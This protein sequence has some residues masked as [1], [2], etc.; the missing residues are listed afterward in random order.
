M[1]A[2]ALGNHEFDLGTS[3]LRNII[4]GLN[5]GTNIRWFG[6]QL[7][8]LSSNLNFSGA[9]ALSTLFTATREQNTFFKSNPSMTAA[10]INATKKLAPSTI[11]TVNGEEIGIVGAT[12]QILA[13]ISSPGATTL[14]GP[15]AA[16]SGNLFC[17]C[18]DTTTG[19][20][21]Q[22]LHG[23]FWDQM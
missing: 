3:E 19:A 7:P 6:A 10:A 4:G 12:T 21:D 8:Y 15:S 16:L 9:C 13:S 14:I 5:S 20:A 11:I 17:I 1:Q 22:Q 2:A 18:L 23:Y